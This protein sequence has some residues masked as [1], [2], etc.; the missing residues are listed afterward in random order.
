MPKNIKRRICSEPTM[1]AFLPEGGDSRAD[2]DPIRMSVDEYETI[3]LID[4]L[5][6]SQEECASHLKVARTTAQLIYN[7]ARKKLA[8][9]IVTGRALVIEGGNYDV[10]DGTCGCPDCVR[11]GK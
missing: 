7:C 9:C 5:G 1:H 11:C 4:L 8:E 3:R 10:C 2:E 6:L